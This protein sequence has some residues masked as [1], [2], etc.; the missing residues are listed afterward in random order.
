[1]TGENRKN[2]LNWSL[3]KIKEVDW[4]ASTQ[5]CYI[6]RNIHLHWNKIGKSKSLGRGF[7]KDQS[8]YGKQNKNKLG[9]PNFSILSIWDQTRIW[10]CHPGT[11][12]NFTAAYCYLRRYNITNNT[13]ATI[14]SLTV[15]IQYLLRAYHKLGTV[16]GTRISHE[17]DIESL[18]S[19][20]NYMQMR[21]NME[22]V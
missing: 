18:C 8:S 9:W 22:Q 7:Q 12:I 14:Y 2:I 4:K 13:L 6:W 20:G 5:N 11:E 10:K 3:F 16:L 19:C 21:T 15:F 17:Q 1:M